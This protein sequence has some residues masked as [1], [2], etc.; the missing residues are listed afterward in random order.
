MAKSRSRKKAPKKAPI[1]KTEQDDFTGERVS[2]RADG[3][4]PMPK[5]KAETRLTKA[6][7]IRA[8]FAG[9][10]AREKGQRAFAASQERDFTK[11]LTQAERNKRE[12]FT[13]EGIASSERR[14]D[15][16]SKP[17]KSM[18]VN[19]RMN[20]FL[21][22]A[23]VPEGNTAPGQAP[24]AGYQGDGGFGGRRK[25]SKGA[26]G[27]IGAP[28]A[29]S[30][31]TGKA[32]KTRVLRSPR[33]I[34]I[35]KKK[36]LTG[37]T[38]TGAYNPNKIVYPGKRSHELREGEVS[39]GM[40]V[41]ESGKGFEHYT[42][43][44]NPVRYHETVNPKTMRSAD[45]SVRPVDKDPYKAADT[46]ARRYGQMSKVG[47][48]QPNSIPPITP[49]SGTSD[50]AKEARIAFFGTK[51]QERAGVNA[52]IGV[53]RERTKAAKEA[54][55][56]DVV[57]GAKQVGGLY[58]E[59]RDIEKAVTLRDRFVRRAGGR[60]KNLDQLP[61][62]DREQA[63]DISGASEAAKATPAAGYY[64]G[65]SKTGEGPVRYNKGL[66]TA[67]IHGI[68]HYTGQKPEHVSSWLKSTKV[69][70]RHLY[71]H[72]D[73]E[74]Y[75][76]KTLK[77]GF[78]VNKDIKSGADAAMSRVTFGTTR[79]SPGR[80]NAGR[81]LPRKDIT[82]DKPDGVVLT[83]A[84]HIGSLI[85]DHVSEQRALSKQKTAARSAASVASVAKSTGE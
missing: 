21:N 2:V 13:A 30:P 24:T 1:V 6:P 61:G 40:F 31:T 16:L 85:S 45:F 26:K 29:V 57:A 23:T 19:K 35:G 65:Q 3:S 17:R 18:R 67:H 55:A 70:A 5:R 59:S 83:M 60:V 76:P 82:L 20:E 74:E 52:Q 75:S 33:D 44:D 73:N 32:P 71:T 49:P 80:D 22:T 81:N 4:T 54:G 34:E 78:V 84:Q 47:R 9:Q 58:G 41:P 48:L 37:F 11:D 10:E 14:G 15:N 68:A 50:P 77:Q 56:G 46:A 38:K 53:K 43:A 63:M 8:E 72:L 51:A 42:A 25:V 12:A 66:K 69:D 7:E 27:S 28:L 62:I 64:R 36:T 79:K 39:K